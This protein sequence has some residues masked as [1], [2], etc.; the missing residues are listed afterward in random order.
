[1]SHGGVGSVS[2]QTGALQ[3]RRQSHIAI[4]SPFYWV[5]AIIGVLIG[6]FILTL[7][8][9]QSVQVNGQ[10]QPLGLVEQLL[11]NLVI[12]F[13]ALIPMI[14]RLWSKFKYETALPA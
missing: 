12:L 8:F 10:A 13:F 7:D 9:S 5:I 2:Y 14:Q 11:I 4:N 6:L 1:M 3:G